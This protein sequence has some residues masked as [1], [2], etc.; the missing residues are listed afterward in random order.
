MRIYLVAGD[1][2]HLGYLV[3]ENYPNILISFAYI[4]SVTGRELNKVRRDSLFIDSGAFTAWATGLK[5]DIDKYI[6]FLQ[7]GRFSV[8]ANM[9]VIHDGEGSYRNYIYMKKHGLTPLPVFHSE[10]EFKWLETYLEMTDYIAI[11]G[12]A[13][14]EYSKEEKYKFLDKCFSIIS[15]HWQKKVHGFG[16]GDPDIML[17]Y[18]FCSVDTTSAMNGSRY[19]RTVTRT[20]NLAIR[21]YTWK[22]NRTYRTLRSQQSWRTRIV[23]WIKYYADIQDQVTEVWK[24]RGVYWNERSEP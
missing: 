17:R 21:H 11:G 9:D 19:G 18:P 14:G 1:R 12:M 24:T 8:Y 5:L 6:E 4:S 13:G 15:K 7:R 16:I 2:S 20:G 3:G 10:E 23:S 22:H